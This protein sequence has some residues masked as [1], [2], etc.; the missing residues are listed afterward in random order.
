[1]YGDAFPHDHPF[2][3]RIKALFLWQAFP[4][5]VYGRKINDCMKTRTATE[6]METM[7]QAIDHAVK[8]GYS[9]NFKL[10]AGGLTTEMEPK[11]YS[12]SEVKI[13]D[14]FRFEGYSDPTDNSILYLIETMDGRKGLLIDAYGAYADARVSKF[15]SAVEDIQ[16]KV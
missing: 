9:E 10:E 11:I 7:N 14:F 2:F 12:S 6:K 4:I 16:K 5:G 8:R 1:M 3:L 13:D 15:I